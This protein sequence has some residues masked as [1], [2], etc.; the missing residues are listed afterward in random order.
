MNWVE[1]I[2]KSVQYIEE[3][4]LASVWIKVKFRTNRWNT[5]LPQPM[6]TSSR[7]DYVH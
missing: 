4:L 1:S 7:K 5:R 6:Q 2:Q 3:H